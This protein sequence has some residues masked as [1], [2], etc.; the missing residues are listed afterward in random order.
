MLLDR[1]SNEQ[2][3]PTEEDLIWRFR[4]Y[5]SEDKRALTKFLRC[6]DFNDPI[7]AKQAIELLER[8]TVCF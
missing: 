2:L 7:E 4:F 6:V 3:T 1:P 8:F 5:L